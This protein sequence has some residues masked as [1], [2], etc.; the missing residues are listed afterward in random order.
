M[1]FPPGFVRLPDDDTES[2]TPLGRLIQGG[3]GGDVRLK[4]YLC[5]TMMATRSPYDIRRNTPTPMT[6]ARLLALPV[7]PGRRRINSNLK[8]LKEN[9]FITLQPRPGAPPVIT[10]LSAT[11]DG[12][13]YTRPVG[14]YIGVPIELW[15]QGW[16]IDL[17]PTAL[18]LLLVLKELLGGHKNPRYAARYRRDAYCLSPDTW[19]RATKELVKHDLLEVGRTPQGSDFDYRRLRNTYWV[20]EERLKTPPT[21][22]ERFD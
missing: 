15:T 18:A 1:A 22:G 9:G 4:L 17:S 7:D 20:D 14:R 19:T 3:R 16:L 13:K 11:G 21:R 2:V 6:W 8:W 5:I 10:L 12:G